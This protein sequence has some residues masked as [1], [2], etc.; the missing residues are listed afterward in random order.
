M[1]KINKKGFAFSELLMVTV[2]VIGI[3]MI[4]Y[5]NIFSIMGELE[6]RNKYNDLSA[7]YVAFYVRK[8]LLNDYSEELDISPSDFYK[9]L[10]S[11]GSSVFSPEFDD[12]LEEAGVE[13]IILSNDYIGNLK[14]I[15]I[16]GLDEYIDYLPNYNNL[17]DTDELYRI[18]VKTKEGYATTEVKFNY[19][20]IGFEIEGQ[21]FKSLSNVSSSPV[22]RVPN[23][24]TEINKNAFVNNDSVTTIYLPK[25]VIKLGNDIFKKENINEVYLYIDKIESVGDNTFSVADGQNLTIN[26]YDCNEEEVEE[27]ADELKITNFESVKCMLEFDVDGGDADE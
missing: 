11:S 1:S 3:F 24:I 23:F 7:N 18:I 13:K 8:A 22:I 27:V 20:E 10:Y 21:I 26:V 16:S 17:N 12:Y 19:N 2:V 15:S 6:N 25:S 9:L 4:I 5:S 14:N